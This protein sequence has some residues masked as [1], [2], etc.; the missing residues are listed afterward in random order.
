MLPATVR[1][2]SITEWL[3]P[4]LNP[5]DP[6]ARALTWSTIASSLSKGVFFS[7]SV[8]YF[9]RV[10]GFP[11]TTV[12]LGLTIAGCLGVGAALGAGYLAR[13]IGARRVMVLATAGQGVALLAYLLARTPAA[14][15]VVASVAVCGQAMQ[16]TA[17][18]TMIAESFTAADRLAVRARLRVVMNVFIAL[19]TALAAIALAIDT[20][21]AY[22]V[23][24]LATGALTLVAAY[25][26]VRARWQPQAT[27]VDTD[28][29]QRTQSGRPMR[30]S[31]L[32]DRTYLAITALYALL[33]MQF[34]LL[35]IG[36]PL[37][38]VG[39]TQTPAVTVAVLLAANTAI[40]SVL[41]LWAAHRTT[42]LHSS[43]RAIAQA[44]ALLALACALYSI[45]AFGSL[46][47]AVAVLV[48]AAIAHSLAEILSEAGSWTLA[49]E[50]ADP[51]NAGAYQG[52]SQTGAALGAMLAPLV[53]TAAIEHG[54]AGW[55]ILAAVFL[56]AALMT[57]AL[58][59]A[60]EGR[61]A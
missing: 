19:G 24:M 9:T 17:L 3:A 35:T 44:G 12:G 7:V 20:R 46:V 53:V 57:Q 27:H 30:R 16:R 15:V 42:D 4:Y 28:P 47:I 10:A 26:L 2:P 58:I 54:A 55:A 43:G 29:T 33:S 37:W 13:A 8:L 59:R 52:V 51:A 31:P 1:R 14:F 6:T 45:A 32:R 25:T 36:M 61:M 18:T 49:F 34:G 5:V 48:L 23:A 50:L 22:Q 21:P 11:A 38:V 60:R 56:A 40:V 39:H 41:Q